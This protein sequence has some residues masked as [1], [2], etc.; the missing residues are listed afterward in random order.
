MNN[1]LAPVLDEIR[2]FAGAGFDFVDLTLEPP[3]A[4]PVDPQAVCAALEEHELR[5]VGHTAF[6]LPIAS[7]YRELRTVARA[8]FAAACDAFATIGAEAVNVHPDPITRSYPRDEA[9][10][11]NADAMREL[12]GVAADRGLRLMVENLGT[13]GLVHHLAPLIEADDRIGFHLDAGHANLGASPVRDLLDAFGDRLAHVHVSDNFGVDDLH[14][15]LG[16]GNVPWPDVVSSLKG[17]D[18]DRTV[19]IEVF[20]RPYLAFSAQLWRDWWR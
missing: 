9:V 17:L 19:T 16:A 7:P 18:Y 6:F 12:A 14:L 13:F 8:L 20:S 4:W 15:P 1:P 2:A 3:G 10:A 11:A 5:V